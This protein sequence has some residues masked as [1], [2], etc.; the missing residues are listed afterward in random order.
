MKIASFYHVYVDG[1]WQQPVAEHFGAVLSSGLPGPVTVGVVG[2]DE[3]FSWLKGDIARMGLDVVYHTAPTGYE[4]V[5]LRLVYQYALDNPD[6][7]ILYCHT[8]GAYHPGP[9]NTAIRRSATRLLV[10]GWRECVAELDSGYDLVGQHWLLPEDYPDEILQ[11]LFDGRPIFSGNFWWARGD[12]L[13]MLP[14]PSD[15]HR[16]EAERWAGTGQ[17][18]V[19]DLRP[20]WP[21]LGLYGHEIVDVMNYSGIPDLERGEVQCHARKSGSRVPSASP[22]ATASR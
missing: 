13:A 14:P 3:P 1:A 21:T 12:Y 6:A 8:K 9:L 2:G 20:G 22:T 18:V 7:A 19:M 11:P 10:N 5:T 17:P 15:A 16:W 4:Q